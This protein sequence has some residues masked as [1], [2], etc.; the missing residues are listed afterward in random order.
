[1]KVGVCVMLMAILISGCVGNTVKLEAKEGEDIISFSY[2]LPIEMTYALID[3]QLAKLAN[4]KKSFDTY[5]EFTA[6]FFPPSGIQSV[7]NNYSKF[8]IKKRA[9][10]DGLVCKKNN[11]LGK[12]EI[13]FLSKVY[14]SGVVAPN[15]TRT[16]V[17]QEVLIKVIAPKGNL[18]DVSYLN[19]L[20]V[21]G[22]KTPY[23]L[24]LHKV[25]NEKVKKLKKKN[26]E[27]KDKYEQE[28]KEEELPKKRTV[29]EKICQ[30]KKVRGAIFVFSGYVERVEGNNVQIRVV[31]SSLKRNSIVTLGGFQPNIIWDSP[32]NWDLCD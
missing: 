31:R 13:L 5:T 20:K 30:E 19:S 14:Y 21:A 22:Y 4:S 27:E 7:I 29:G 17:S 25:W 10:F 15:A 32:E 2:R 6:R 23:E 12:E 26:K 24:Q 9:Y 1:M 16:S 3:K 11:I 8:C 28:R 18:N